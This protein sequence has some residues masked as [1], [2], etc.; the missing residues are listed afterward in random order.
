MTRTIKVRGTIL[1]VSGLILAVGMMVLT[2]LLWDTMFPGAS[3]AESGLRFAGS[4]DDARLVVLV[5][6]ALML[7]GLAMA[8]YGAWMLKTGRESRIAKI[9][10][11]VLLL[12]LVAAALLSGER[13]RL[14]PLIQLI[15]R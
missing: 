12:G 3:A 11:I 13:V 10:A 5:F 1:I 7:L 9:I 8:G 6:A 4:A 15:G 14:G 2:A